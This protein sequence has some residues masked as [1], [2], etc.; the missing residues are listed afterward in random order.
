M[1]VRPRTWNIDCHVK[2]ARVNL[3]YPVHET[4]EPQRAEG[5]FRERA[6]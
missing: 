5:A 2:G 6:I 4:E 1:E 3:S